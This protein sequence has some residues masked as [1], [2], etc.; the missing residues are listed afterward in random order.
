MTTETDYWKLRCEA[1]EKTLNTDAFQL[2][3]YDKNWEAWQS[4]VNNP[5]EIGGGE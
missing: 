2:E 3:E 4:L 5:P 1:A